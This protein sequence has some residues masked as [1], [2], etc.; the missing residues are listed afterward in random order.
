MIKRDRIFFFR[1]TAKII[2]LAF[3][4]KKEEG[5][6]GNGENPQI[7]I[8]YVAMQIMVIKLNKNI[9]VIKKGY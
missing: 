3:E 8:G 4:M 7:P 2:L 5:G 6:W 9:K 1:I